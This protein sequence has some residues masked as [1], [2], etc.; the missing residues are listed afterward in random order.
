MNKLQWPYLYGG[1]EL[2]SQID[3]LIEFILDN[4][5]SV[6]FKKVHEDVSNTYVLVKCI[7]MNNEED[8]YSPYLNDYHADYFKRNL[9]KAKLKAL[10]K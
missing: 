2:L 7:N 4:V 3:M 6:S 5:V 8:D 1:P 10:A 9:R